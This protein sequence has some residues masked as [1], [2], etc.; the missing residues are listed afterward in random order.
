MRHQAVLDS[1]Y[2]ERVHDGDSE[3]NSVYCDIHRWTSITS[4]Q[5]DTVCD[6]V[7]VVDGETVIQSSVILPYNTDAGY[8]RHGIKVFDQLLADHPAKQ[9]LTFVGRG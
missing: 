6:T 2:V 3:R 7:V 8:Q 4:G 5:R 9:Y 1:I